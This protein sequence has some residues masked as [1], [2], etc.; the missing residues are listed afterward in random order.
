MFK[1]NK[2]LKS[3]FMTFLVTLPSMMNIG[4]MVALLVL[5]YSI[6]GVY[7]FAEVKNNGALNA[8]LN[9]Q[10]IGNAF[11]AMVGAMTGE[12]WPLVMEALSRQ[13]EP[14]FECIPDPSYQDYLDNKC[15]FIIINNLKA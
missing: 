5:I 14:G 3:T 1:R 13:N 4:S 15:K 8:Q 7:L 10:T 2:A 9:F 6:L 12:K 11:M